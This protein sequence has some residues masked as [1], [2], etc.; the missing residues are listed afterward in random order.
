MALSLL[1]D[2]DVLIKCACYS[3]LGEVRAPNNAGGDLGILGAAPFVVRGYLQRRGSISDRI[4]A[5]RC[6][7]S[8]LSR[9]VILEPTEDELRLAT[10]I[11][12]T[13]MEQGLDLDSG[14]SQLCAMA[15]FRMS[16]FLLTGDKRAICGAESLQLQ[17]SAL[18]SLHG[19]VV[20]LEQAIRGIANRMG[21]LAA[22]SLICAE[23]AVDKSLSICFECDR[24]PARPEFAAEGLQ[25]YIR[26]L[27]TQAPLLLYE[28]DAL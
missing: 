8:C 23:A 25:S 7:D 28:A 9:A 26:Y 16:P 17:V 20:C 21:P 5:Q 18:S 10:I 27:R 13:A 24:E 3:L 14:E 12:E 2:N 11:E 22:R 6:F 1:I 4:A 15:V 19:R